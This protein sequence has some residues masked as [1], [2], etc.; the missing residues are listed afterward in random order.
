[1]KAVG[2]ILAGTK[3]SRLEV[4][5]SHR[6]SAA[7]PVGGSYRVIDFALTNFSYSGVK[8]IALISQYNTRS[9]AD[10]VSSSKWWNLG[11]KNSGIYLFTP[12]MLN[13]DTLSFKGTA[14]AIYQNIEFLKKSSEKYVIISP[15]DHIMRI[16][17]REVLKYHVEKK[18]D[19]TVVYKNMPE[20]DARNYG[21]LELDEQYRLTDFE[22]KP[23]EPQ[24]TNISL[25]IYV[26]A[27]ELLIKLL[28]DLANEGRTSIADDI[29]TRYRKK[30]RIYGYKFEGYWQALKDIDSL[31]AT[32]LD[33]LNP[34]MRDEIFEKYSYV[35]TK[36]KDD[37]PVKYSQGC[38]VKNSI[39]NGGDVI[40][41]TVHDSVLSRKV[42]IGEGSYIKNAIIMEGCTIG[43][44]TVVENA[45]LDKSVTIGD[46]KQI[47]GTP[48]NIKVIPK[49]QII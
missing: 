19:I 18:A 44:G 26:I 23:L 31:Y 47:I 45:I 34:D 33:F 16:D 35:L 43:K 4:L 42:F 22:E 46:G 10:H 32:N 3:K 11:R 37:P 41:G 30:L 12:D 6:N 29:I 27:R 25:G 38:N 17:Y 21:T 24:T 14:D 7:M 20:I 28:E 39:L 5:A 49:G 9:L 48:D 36:A 1:M 2:I 13:S 8:T 15:S 40:N